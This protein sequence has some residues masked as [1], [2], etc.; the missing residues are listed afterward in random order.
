MDALQDTDVATNNDYTT[1]SHNY[2]LG[3]AHE[4]M[5]ANIQGNIIFDPSSQLPREVLLETTLKAFGYNMDLWEVCNTLGH[6]DQSFLA[7]SKCSFTVSSITNR[8]HFNTNSRNKILLLLC[9]T[10]NFFQLTLPICH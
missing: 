1:K 5:Q 9:A 6:I 10:W 8:E 4:S 7:V 2:K 3:M